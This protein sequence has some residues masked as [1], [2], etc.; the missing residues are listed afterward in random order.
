MTRFANW[1]IRYRVLVIGLN[2]LLTVAGGIAF[3]KW[4]YI[5]ADFSKFLPEDDP[6]VLRFNEAGDRFGGVAVAMVGVEFDDAFQPANLRLIDQMTR[7]IEAVP[8]VSWVVSLTRMDDVQGQVI[9]GEPTVSVR[10]VVDPNSLPSNPDEIAALRRYVL[11]KETLVG[12]VVSADTRLANLTLGIDRSADRVEVATAV[13]QLMRKTGRDHKLYFAGFPYWMK[14]LSEIILRDMLVLVPVVSLVVIAILFLAFRSIRGVVLP[15]I[16]VMISSTWAMGLMAALGIPITML[17][18]VIPVLLIALGTAYAI[19]LL[20]KVDELDVSEREDFLPHLRSAMVDVMIPIGLAGLTTVIGFLSF[21]T[22]NLLFIQHFGLMAAFG[23]FSAMLVALTLLPAIL[24][25]L[26]PARAGKQR[27]GHDSGWMSRGLDSLGSLVASRSKWVLAAGAGLAL[28]SAAF[29]PWLDRQFNM[30]AYFPTDSEVRQADTMMTEQLGGNVPVWVTVEGNPKDPFVLDQMLTVEKFLS[31]IPD[32]SNVKSV[33]GLI[34]QM[35]QAML[36][37]F[38]TPATGS[39]IG[40]LWFNLEGKAVLN[41]FVDKDATHALIQGVSKS[42][43]TA[44]LRVIMAELEAFL[45]ALPQ[46]AVQVDLVEADPELGQRARLARLE[47]VA[48]NISL[49]LAHRIPRVA[50]SRQQVFGWL[51]SAAAAPAPPLSSAETAKQVA[52]FLRSDESDLEF[53]DAATIIALS[54]AIGESASRGPVSRTAV[55]AIVRQHLPAEAI[56]DDPDSVRFLSKSLALLVDELSDKLRNAALLDQILVH[57]PAPA[58]NDSLLL[59]DLT[60]DLAP[61]QTRIAWLPLGAGPPGPGGQASRA[62]FEQTGMHHISVN[63]DS[64]L[65]YSQLSSLGLAGLMA[66]LLLMIQFRSVVAGL[67]GM[68]PMV[69]TLLI[70]FGAMAALGINLETATVLI[71]SLVVGVGIDYTIH[72]LSRA[73][74]EMIRSGD[75]DG[76]LRIAQR[77]AGRAI[78]INAITV[79]AGQLVFLAG[80]L[81]PLHHF[82]ILLALAMVSSALASITVMPAVLVITRPAFLHRQGARWAQST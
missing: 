57:L 1:V 24:S 23:I 12:V 77:T 42:S 37:Q 52:A 69:L 11:G 5:E 29:I 22:S 32:L 50:A 9:D 18:N 15:L 78:L 13:E 48:L 16:T 79:T 41:Q 28:L 81:I 33:A 14:N 65:V 72:Y 2:L 71:A 75:P 63:V 36:G 39:G 40:N 34:A 60:G 82:G 38:S 47:H 4:A 10:P 21:M 25:Y 68:I 27:R 70:N 45:K 61:L 51:E 20:H 58:R 54:N 55:E 76:A 43:D 19:H 8:G 7:E 30:V 80:E 31:S 46:Q 73:R 64:R 62:R 74:L 26:R 44:R 67:L 35:N 66:M 17:S 56:A 3:A 53:E 6:V 49:D 59:R